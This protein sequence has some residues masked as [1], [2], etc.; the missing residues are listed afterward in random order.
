MELESLKFEDGFNMDKYLQENETDR[1]QFYDD[2]ILKQLEDEM[3][4]DMNDGDNKE[5][6]NVPQFLP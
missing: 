4:L 1:R 5:N 2:S 6:P 3:R